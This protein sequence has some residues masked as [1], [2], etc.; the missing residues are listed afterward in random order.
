M[1]LEEFKAFFDKS[2]GV[3]NEYKSLSSEEFK[4]YQTKLCEYFG[5]MRESNLS[6]TVEPQ[7]ETFTTLSGVKY[8][9]RRRVSNSM[10]DH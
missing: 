8:V 5:V 9:F 7:E 3:M 6:D 10:N 4:T 1:S 2:V